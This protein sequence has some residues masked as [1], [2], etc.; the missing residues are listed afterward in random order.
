MLTRSLKEIESQ[1]RLTFLRS[2]IIRRVL[3][4]KKEQCPFSS[5]RINTRGGGGGRR[6]WPTA[7]TRLDPPDKILSDCSLRHVVLRNA[8]AAYRVPR[9]LAGRIRAHARSVGL[10][11]NILIIKN[12]YV[13]T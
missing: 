13:V 1:T 12:Y 8:R 2:Q 9:E 3:D 6:V 7:Y 11:A 4:T 5:F 10:L